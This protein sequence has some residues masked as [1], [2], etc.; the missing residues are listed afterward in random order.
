MFRWSLER[1]EF[2]RVSSVSVMQLNG[3]AVNIEPAKNFHQNVNVKT[4]AN[5][6]LTMFSEGKKRSFEGKLCTL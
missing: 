1:T 5:P 4:M 6:V 2:L 3:R